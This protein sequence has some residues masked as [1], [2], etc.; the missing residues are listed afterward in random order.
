MKFETSEPWLISLVDY[1]IIFLFQTTLLRW[2]T[3]LIGSQTVILTILLF[4][5]YFLLMLVFFYNGFPF[6]GKF[7]SCSCPSFYLFS[8]NSLQNTC[9]DACFDV[10]GTVFVI[11]WWEDISNSVLLLLVHFASRF[12]LQL[13]CKSLIVTIRSSFTCLHPFHLLVL[14]P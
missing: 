3:F 6:I 2:L 7:W 8:I 1:V 10:F 14:L 5:I 11:I 9:F 4:W 13:I 12:R